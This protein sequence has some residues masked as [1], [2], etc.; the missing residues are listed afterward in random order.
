M[1]LLFAL[2]YIALTVIQVMLMARIVLDVVQMFARSWRPTGLA[3]IVASFVYRITDP[4]MT[5][6]RS[7]VKPVNLG[8]MQLDLAFLL[9]YFA[10]FIAKIVVAQLAS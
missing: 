3:L 8:G 1:E 2:V 9:L 7:K 10:V 5:W 6:V 4:P